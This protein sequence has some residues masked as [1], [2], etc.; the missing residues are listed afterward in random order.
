MKSRD[1]DLGD[2]DKELYMRYGHVAPTRDV[3]CTEEAP[4]PLVP[5]GCLQKLP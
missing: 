4:A 1:I 5:L 3:T 2:S